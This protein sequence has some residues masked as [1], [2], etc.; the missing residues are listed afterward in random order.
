MFFILLSLQ[1]SEKTSVIEFY[2]YFKYLISLCFRKKFN[3]WTVLV[4]NIN[5]IV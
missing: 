4:T 2:K 1:K 3:P 5:R